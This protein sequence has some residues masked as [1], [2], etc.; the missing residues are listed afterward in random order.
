MFNVH[1]FWQ[2]IS[3]L[4]WIAVVLIVFFT[5]RSKLYGL[6]G[7]QN[8]TIKV[9]GFELSVAD[10]TQKIGVDV[11]DLQKRLADLEN[12]VH[13][14]VPTRGAVASADD[15]DQPKQPAPTDTRTTS[16]LWVDD[17]PSNN[18]FLIEQCRNDG[19]DV[20]IALTTK[21]A[22]NMF[23]ALNPSLVITDLGRRED[24]VSNSF[25]GMDLITAIRNTGST[26]PIVV[27]AGQR[28]V[29]N[30]DK[31]LQAGAQ[32]VTQSAVELQGWIGGPR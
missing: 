9:A 17:V 28:G 4:L 32:A 2:F 12:E 3:Q 27:Y 16:I 1:E 14:S 24:G 26:V 18:A 7:R 31:L 23:G 22:M 13:S 5:V 20:E 15:E 6:L 8:V 21:Q 29:Q 19:I 30:R 10:A 25:A 11:T